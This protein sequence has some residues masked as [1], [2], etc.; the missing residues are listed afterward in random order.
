MVYGE[1]TNVTT[2]NNN[3]VYIQYAQHKRERERERGPFSNLL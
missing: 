1:Q 3:K 2:I